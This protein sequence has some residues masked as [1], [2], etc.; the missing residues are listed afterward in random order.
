MPRPP[1]WRGARRYVWLFAALGIGALVR[2]WDLTGQSLFIDEG[3]VFHI[4]EHTPRDILQLVANTDFHPPLFYLV[5]HWLLKLGWPQWDYRYLTAAFSLLGI[6][7]T[8]GIARR[9]FGDTAAAIAALALATQP[10]LVQW[11]RL[12]RMYAVLVALGAVSW[13][14]LLRAQDDRTSRRWLWWTAY[15]L[16]AVALPYVH[17][18]GA[19]VVASQG[20]YALVRWRELWP[21]L[22]ADL[23]SGVALIPW[24]WAIRIQYPH[25]GLVLR[26]DSPDFS[27]PT[28]IRSTLVSS[29]PPEWV[30]KSSFDLGISVVV[31]AVILAGI[32][33]GRRTMLP[34]YFLP[35]VVHVI[36]SLATG[37]DLV[38]PRYLYVYLPAFCI[39]LGAVCAA[40]L[41]TRYRLGA[42]AL[43]LAYAGIAAICIPNMLFVPYYQFPDWYEVNTLLLRNEHRGDLIIMDQG[44]EYWVVHNFTGFR[45]HQ[46]E[47]PAIPSDL[48]STILWLRGYPKRRVWYIENQ[49]GFTDPTHRI[50][51]DLTATRPRLGTWRQNREY[52]EDIVRVVLY[53][54][55]FGSGARKSVVK[56]ESP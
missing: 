6:A 33:L 37:K 56:T 36:G 15:G 30:L 1:L 2:L 55:R 16:C 29:I 7:A 19:L 49:P 38:I 35:I 5:T 23:L 50:E 54:P 47:G 9:G 48:D 32:V 34:Y 45:E 43:L 40:W 18:V 41:H 17:Y 46:M 28:T 20:L 13:W 24:L 14:L 4:S 26:L 51:R 12:F 27:W 44:A 31:V 53:G 3:F 10:A 25:G 11:D 21:A 39:S 52:R 22:V 42:V 8:W